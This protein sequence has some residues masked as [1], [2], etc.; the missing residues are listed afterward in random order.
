[1][2]ERGQYHGQRLKAREVLRLYAAG[3]RDFRGAILRGCN[4]RGADLSEA[5][6]SGADIRSA[7][8]VNAT[9]WRAKFCHAQGGLQRRWWL[10]QLTVV[11]LS[12]SVLNFV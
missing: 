9:L 3:E 10:G 8:F 7:R 12:E 11:A 5:D 1:M 6:F 2:V 4:F